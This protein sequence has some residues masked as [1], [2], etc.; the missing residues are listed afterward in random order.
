MLAIRPAASGAS[1]SYSISISAPYFVVASTN[2]DVIIELLTQQSGVKY[3]VIIIPRASIKLVGP[4]TVEGA[5][6]FSGN[7][8]LH[9]Q[10]GLHRFL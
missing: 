1:V 3:A 7:P 4:N 5:G 6:N 10:Y 9:Q 8:R 2:S